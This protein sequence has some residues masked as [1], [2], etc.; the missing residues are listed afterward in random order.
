MLENRPVIS[1]VATAR[2]GEAAAFY[3][4]VLG[5]RLVEDSPFALVFDLGGGRMLRVQKLPSHAAAAHTVLGW[6]V[7]DIAAAVAA[8]VA[9]GVAFNRYP[10]L[11]QDADGVW[12]TPDG[13][14]VAW[15]SDPDGN[16][17]SL[18]QFAR[19]A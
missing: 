19:P 1:F 15:F 16:G 5:F 12:T 11:E 13:H 9:R 2:P 3:A 7:A 6:D 4:D 10:R 18:T 14:K 17:L 8:M